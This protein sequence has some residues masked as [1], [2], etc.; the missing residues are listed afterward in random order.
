MERV[1]I[2]G[3]AGYLGSILCERLLAAGYRVTVI[4]NLMYG[5]GSLFHLCANPSFDFILGDVRDESC[6]AP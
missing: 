4:D 5:Q 3:G 6:L 1:L 2:T